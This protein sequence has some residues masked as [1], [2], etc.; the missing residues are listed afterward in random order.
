L[1][2]DV[3]A[4]DPDLTNPAFDNCPGGPEQ[5]VLLVEGL[6]DTKASHDPNDNGNDT[7]GTAFLVALGVIPAD[8][9]VADPEIFGGNQGPQ[10]LPGVLSTRLKWQPVIAD[11]GS[12][13]LHYY[14]V[15]RFG[16]IDCE[17]IQI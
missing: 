2:L 9:L 12:Y 16:C 7:L 14:A 8:L 15:D 17:I 6:E 3:S 5:V 11:V 13:C 4:T 1:N 10:P